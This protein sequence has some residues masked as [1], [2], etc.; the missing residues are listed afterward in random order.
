MKYLIFFSLL[1]SQSLMAKSILLSGFDAFNGAKENNSQKVAKLIQEKFKDTDIKVHYCQ[2]RTVYFK[3]AETLKD[4]F[5]E[6]SEKPDFIISLG[7]GFCS[8]V[9]FELKAKN[10][11]N[12][13]TPDNDGVVYQRKVIVN[14]GPR[15][16]ALSL[17]FSSIYKMMTKEE[18][19]YVGMSKDPGKFVCNNLAYLMAHDFNEVPFG[20]IHV[21]A[22]NCSRQNDLITR[23]VESISITIKKLF[24]Q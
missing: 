1:I 2:L 9:E 13:A 8:G 11:M 14:G 12:S 23:S 7:E 17:N 5:N 3:S 15:S 18:R 21:P 22:H 4:C 20:F 19:K 24:D 16:L 6:L 10:Q